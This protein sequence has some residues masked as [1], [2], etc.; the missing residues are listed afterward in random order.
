MRSFIVL[1]LP[2]LLLTGC[3][4]KPSFEGK[5]TPDPLPPHA[6]EIVFELTADGTMTS[7]VKSKESGKSETMKGKWK[8]TGEKTAEVTPDESA[9]VSPGSA[10]IELIDTDTLEFS[11][12]GSKEKMKLKR[13]K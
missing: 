4:S 10:K 6:T 12:A 9:I 11:E 5:W 3:G 13:K 7:T 1:V 8:K 2:L